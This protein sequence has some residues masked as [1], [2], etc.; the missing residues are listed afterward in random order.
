MKRHHIVGT[1]IELI[2]SAPIDIRNMVIVCAC[3]MINMKWNGLDEFYGFICNKATKCIENMINSNK[4][5]ER[6]KIVKQNKSFISFQLMTIDGLLMWLYI[7]QIQSQLI[8]SIII[9]SILTQ[10]IHY[11]LQLI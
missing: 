5:K 1:V 8:E 4:G 7:K 6:E 9:K 11:Q 2:H 10:L 3:C